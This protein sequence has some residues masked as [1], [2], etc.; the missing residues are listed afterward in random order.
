MFVFYLIQNIVE[1]FVSPLEKHQL[2][3]EGKESFGFF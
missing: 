3:N 1:V 2:S